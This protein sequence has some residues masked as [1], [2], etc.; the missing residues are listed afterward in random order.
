[1][2]GRGDQEDKHKVEVP[3]RRAELIRREAKM[4]PPTKD[5]RNAPDIRRHSRKANQPART[6]ARKL[7]TL[8]V[9]SGPNAAVT[10]EKRMLAP[11]T[12]SG[13][14]TLAPTGAQML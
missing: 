7:R 5:G 11:G 9:T 8:Y 4:Y 12:R 2:D 3:E 14:A 10:G 6:G 13:C 1:M